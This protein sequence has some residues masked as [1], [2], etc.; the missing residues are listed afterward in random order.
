MTLYLIPCQDFKGGH[1]LVGC[2]R[3]RRL[4]GHE[5]DEGLEG[6]DAHTVG[7]HYTH[8]A[9]ELILTLVATERTTTQ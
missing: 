6:D 2:V 8:D 1:D 4:A 3:V 9:G 7:I 5:V